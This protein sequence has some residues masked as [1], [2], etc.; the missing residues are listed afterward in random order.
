MMSNHFFSH[1]NM[2]DEPSLIPFFKWG[3]DKSHVYIGIDLVGVQNETLDYKENYFKWSG[4]HNQR[5][6]ELEFELAGLIK[7]S[8][9]YRESHTLPE[10]AWEKKDS[11]QPP[12]S[13]VMKENEKY[14]Y[15]GRCRLDFVKWQDEEEPEMSS[16]GLNDA[17][18]ND[19]DISEMMAKLQEPKK[20][21]C[22]ES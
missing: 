5:K 10:F 13:H 15:K 12:W 8:T 7:A 18:E 22:P 14:K 17:G 11:K 20:V 6:Y 19:L 9:F 2:K 21:E 1:M 4:M 3:Q 16:F